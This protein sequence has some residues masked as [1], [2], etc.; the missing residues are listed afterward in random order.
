MKFGKREISFIAGIAVALLIWLAPIP[1]LEGDAKIMFA[2][3]IMTV[4]FWATGVAQNGYT[5]GLLLTLMCI[6]LNHDPETGGTPIATIF[7]AWTGTTIWLV[8]GAYL[9][10][11][12]VK[13][14]GLG[15]RIAYL[16]MKSFV[17]D[18]TSIIIGVFVLTAIMSLL[19][20][21]PWPRA[22]LLMAVMKV[23]IDS[24]GIVQEDATKIGFAVFAA[25]V[26]CSLI[27]ITGDAVINPLA[28]S[29]AG[30]ATFMQWLLYM[31]VPSLIFTVITVV[32]F[33]FLF[34]P[35]QDYS[36][37]KEEID[38]KLAEMGKLGGRELKTLVWVIIAIVLWM[39]DS[40]HGIDIGWVTLGIG[41]LLAMPII[42]DL[43][44]AKDWSAVPI[45]VLVFLTA[46]MAIGKVG[47][48]TGM[49]AW[50]ASLLPSQVAGGAVVIAC[51]I[52]LISF[53]V[54]MLLGSVIAVMGVAVPAI[55]A[56]AEP[57]GI[58]AMA[59]TLVCYMAV[60]GHYMFPFQ[61]LNTLVGASPDT[62]MY[63]QNETLKLGAF[64]I[65]VLF[66]M[67]ILMAFWFQIIGIWTA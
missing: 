22:F 30:G 58:G 25:S 17:K 44:G 42:G 60:A 55:L 12:A 26:P 36:V 59:A 33:L 34:K 57:L 45:H 21:H 37:N 19:I 16:Y 35:T 1:G 31:G 62:G 47:G 3:T 27:F 66:I 5:A 52:V 15:D 14:S 51:I 4:I 2:L 18:Y 13:T 56:F 53:C 29:Y 32:L 65:P 11:N 6:L 50:I 23:V 63:T 10:A 40:V 67:G 46:A 41:M 9:I 7:Y 43:N 54:H 8:I 64:L 49:N 61:H 48:T 39:T 28:A 20:P 38:R 24:S